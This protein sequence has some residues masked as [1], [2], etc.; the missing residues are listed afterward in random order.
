MA[1]D[2]MVLALKSNASSQLVPPIVWSLLNLIRG[3]AL[4]RLVQ[5]PI[6]ALDP[7]RDRDFTRDH[8]DVVAYEDFS[9]SWKFAGDGTGKVCGRV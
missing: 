5:F 2:C 3:E 4:E 1:Q 6:G 7:V 9:T 8:C